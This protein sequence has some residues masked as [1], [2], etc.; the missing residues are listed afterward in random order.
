MKSKYG[1]DGGNKHRGVKNNSGNT[2]VLLLVL[3]GIINPVIN[4]KHM[5][6]QVWRVRLVEV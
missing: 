1:L 6:K 3:L 2:T 4:R 5:V